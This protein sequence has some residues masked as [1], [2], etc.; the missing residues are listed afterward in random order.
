VS[1]EPGQHAVVL[2][3]E[4]TA[5]NRPRWGWGKP[6]H[7]GIAARLSREHPAF[8]AALDLVR[9]HGAGLAEIDRGHREDEQPCWDNEMCSGLDGASIYAFL[10]ERNPARYVEVGSGY[11]TKFAAK[12]KRDGGLRTEIVSI[13][14]R[15]RQSV[16]RLCDQVIRRRLEQTDPA[17]FAALEPGDVLF[18]DGSHRLYM[19][20]DVSTF[21]LEVLPSLPRGLLTAVHDIVLPEDYAPDQAD[22]YWTEQYMLAMA[23][24]S[25]HSIRPVLPCHYVCV[26]P[27][28]RA[29]LLAVWD[30][31]GLGGVNAYGTAFW[32]ERAS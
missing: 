32:F 6:W 14:P 22:F 31:V 23:L 24:L 9:G 12:A 8:L 30:D 7:E 15:P 13:D 11:S 4:P 2:E 26:E 21:F 5:D 20:N 16:D 27:G 29:E 18:F 10:R 25:G 19:N 1:L 17:L 3:Q 28:L